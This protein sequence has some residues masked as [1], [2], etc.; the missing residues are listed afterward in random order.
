MQFDVYKNSNSD[1]SE[2]FPYL[3]DIQADVLSRLATRIIVPL[4][5][6][7]KIKKIITVINPTIQIEDKS[8]VALFDELSS[9]PKSSLIDKVSNVSMDHDEIMKAIDFTIQGY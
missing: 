8:L 4:T 2:E 7:A 9:Y 1:T 6:S 3:L 5:P